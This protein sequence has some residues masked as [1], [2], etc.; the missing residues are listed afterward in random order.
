M[1]N[2]NKGK[3]AKAA[4]AAD[5]DNRLTGKRAATDDER[6]STLLHLGEAR[7]VDVRKRR[8]NAARSER[9][10]EPRAGTRVR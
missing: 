2:E 8:V 3:S 10:R 9:A 6:V 4:M 7:S 1:A 5:F